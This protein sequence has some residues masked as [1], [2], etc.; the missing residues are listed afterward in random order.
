MYA[1]FLSGHLCGP[2]AGA[3]SWCLQTVICGQ[4]AELIRTL[5]VNSNSFS[6]FMKFKVP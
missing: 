3:D 2:T 1:L 6:R 5:H 4:T